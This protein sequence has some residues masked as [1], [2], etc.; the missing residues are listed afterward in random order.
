MRSRVTR[1]FQVTIPKEIREALGI[2]VGDI[3]VWEISE[4]GVAILKKSETKKNLEDFRGIWRTHPL[5][6]KFGN[7]VAATRWLRGHEV[8]D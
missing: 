6:K 2:N 7:S 8:N 5:L 4:N 1:K 3:V